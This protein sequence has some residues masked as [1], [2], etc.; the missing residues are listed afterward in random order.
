MSADGF[1]TC[2][3]FDGQAEE[4]AHYYVSI[5]K[6]SRLGRI[7]RFSESEHG[8][9]GSVMAVDFVANGQKFV[10]LNGGPQF[11]FDEAISFQ[12]HCEDQEEVDHYWNKFVEDGGEAGPCGW[13][14][15]KF[16]LSW[17]V[18]PSRLIDLISDP[19]TEKAARTAQAMY[20]MSKLDIA[21]LEKAY[22]GE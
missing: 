21:A 2:L 3:W 14:K 17:Q 18:V 10:A 6:N 5:F 8:T 15:D 22:A 4:A 13:I 7:A 19:D 1:T 9:A 16:G 12:I 20:K 11:T